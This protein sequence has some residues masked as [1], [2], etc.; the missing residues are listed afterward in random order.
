MQQMANS[1]RLQKI[2]VIAESRER[3]N[4]IKSVSGTSEYGITILTS[5]V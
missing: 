3:P 5:K 4:P 1:R 2:E